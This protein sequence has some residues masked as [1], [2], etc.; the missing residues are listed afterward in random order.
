LRKFLIVGVLILVASVNLPLASAGESSKST[1]YSITSTYDVKNLGPSRAENVW[2]RVLLFRDWSGWTD[3]RILST[4]ISPKEDRTENYFDGEN[5]MARAFVFLGELSSGE[6]RTITITQVIEVGAIDMRINPGAVGAT[7][8]PGYENFTKHVDGLWESGYSPIASKARELTDNEP[9]L[10]SKVER[11]I[12]FVENYLTYKY[13]TQEHGARWAWQMGE[14]DC[15]EYTNLF[16]ALCRAVNIPTKSVTAYGYKDKLAPNMLDMGHAFALVYLPN[17]DWVP[18]DL[19][20]PVKVASYGKLDYFHINFSV[21]GY[22]SPPG[23][24]TT[25][26]VSYSYTGV[27]PTWSIRHAGSTI[28]REVG[29]DP[30]IN[31][32]ERMQDRNLPL[33]VTVKN[34]GRHAARNLKVE[35]FGDQK[36]FE[37]SEPKSISSLSPG[38]SQVVGLSIRTTAE[39]PG[40]RELT[41]RVTYDVEYAGE[42]RAFVAESGQSV[43]IPKPSRVVE[44]LT[45]LMPVLLAVVIALLAVAI[46]LAVWRR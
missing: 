13:Q 44:I 19:T 14:G 41:A 42:S 34:D 10:Y 38:Q 5:E 6:N 9:N 15:T 32:G 29:V 33:T 46:A 21:S 2:G 1:I 43:I 18:V 31:I 39:A 16:I 8:P 17:F 35:V 12:D 40:V 3:Q 7:I 27:K 30:S 36:Y 25:P 11:I 28:V 45:E 20:W 24:N 23:V 37:Q 4:N 26:S 22:A